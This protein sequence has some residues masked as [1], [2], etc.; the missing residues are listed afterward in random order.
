MEE[1]H[2]APPSTDVDAIQ[3]PNNLTN[4][5]LATRWSHHFHNIMSIEYHDWIES[6]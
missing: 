2:D 1:Q 4:P 6:M 5:T 3:P